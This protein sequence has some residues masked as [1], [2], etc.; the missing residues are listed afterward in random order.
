MTQLR[1]RFAALAILASVAATAAVPAFA[2]A[3]VTY[4]SCTNKPPGAWCD[5][6]ANSSFDGLN[7]WQYA[8]AADPDFA[9]LIVCEGLFNT[10]TGAFLPTP[11]CA[12]NFTS[13]NYAN[14]TCGCIEANV[15]HWS[16]VGNEAING[17]ADTVP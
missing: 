1:A 10:S 11:T 16:T 2:E 4:F 8:W 7:N 6:R 9:D 17:F 5:G 15:I 13:Q 14:Q 3:A 12:K